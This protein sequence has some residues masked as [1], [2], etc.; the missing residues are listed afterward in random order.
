[1]NGRIAEQS[2]L[3]SPDPSMQAASERPDVLGQSLP[4]AMPS[5]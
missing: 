3:L 1:L 5:A 2:L 4:P